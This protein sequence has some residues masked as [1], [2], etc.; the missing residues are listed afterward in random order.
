[1]TKEDIIYSMER[2]MNT[3]LF[4]A[5]PDVPDVDDWEYVY[6]LAKEICEE[7]KEE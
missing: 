1:M 4:Y 3:A 2:I 7:L 5:H 6:S